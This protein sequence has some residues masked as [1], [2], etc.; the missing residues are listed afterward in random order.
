MT[1]KK[2]NLAYIAND[3]ARKATFKKRKKGLLKKMSELSTLCAI[4]TCAIIY[5]PYDPEPEVWPSP[6]G[7][8]SV[9][10]RFKSMPEMEQSKKMVNQESFLMQRITKAED[11]LKKQ[12][13][14]SRELEMTQVMYKSLVGN[15]GLQNLGVVDLNDLGWLIEKTVEEIGE[16]IKSLRE[17]IMPPP[18][19][20]TAGHI[21]RTSQEIYGENQ[22]LSK[23]FKPNDH[24]N[25]GF[26][27]RNEGKTASHDDENPQ[28]LMEMLRSNE[29]VGRNEGCML[30]YA[31]NNNNNS[32]WSTFNFP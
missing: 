16:R 30:P 5:S 31:L 29:S 28:W 20:V 2:V 1:R 3:S 10:A 15:Q 32:L 9:I 17:Q 4:Q 11:Q 26:G 23:E 22:Q 27:L 25:A 6:L 19:V 12:Q 14:E 21:N 24:Q 13:R 7:A 18:Q 8:Q